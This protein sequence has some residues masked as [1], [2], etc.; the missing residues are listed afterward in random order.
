MKLYRTGK[1]LVLQTAI[2]ACFALPISALADDL[3][4]AQGDSQTISADA[5]YDAVVVNGSLTVANGITLTCT[6]LTVA[7]NI[8]GTATL[9][10]GDGEVVNPRQ[11]CGE[12]RKC[13]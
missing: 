8:N 1:N 10:V 13:E 2:A 3:A 12:K 4:V 5:T 7:D 11:D 9:T 6:S